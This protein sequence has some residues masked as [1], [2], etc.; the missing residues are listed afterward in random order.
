MRTYRRLLIG[1]D[2]GLA[3]RLASMEFNLMTPCVPCRAMP[4][5]PKHECKL[6][7][8]NGRVNVVWRRENQGCGDSE[9]AQGP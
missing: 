2:A 9:P 1:S 6:S 7:F 8:T 4:W 5:R 3:G